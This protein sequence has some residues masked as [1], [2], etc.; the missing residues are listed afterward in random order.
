M[1]DDI[2]SMGEWE[3][4]S[5]FEALLSKGVD[6]VHPMV[7]RAL[8]RAD[9]SEALTAANRAYS[10][11]GPKDLDVSMTY[12][13][14]LLHRG[15][16]DEAMLMIQNQGLAVLEDVVVFVDLVLH[17]VVDVQVLLEGAFHDIQP[18]PGSGFVWTNSAER[19]P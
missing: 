8:R 1:F 13:I 2:V 3:T 16:V 6:S 4:V 17:V 14:L 9:L 15:L 11:E 7:L 5:S 10:Q 18:D 19:R 12:A